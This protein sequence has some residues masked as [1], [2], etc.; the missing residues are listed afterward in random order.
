MILLIFHRPGVCD[1]CVKS[2]FGSGCLSF[3]REPERDCRS[4]GL[5]G[6]GERF[7]FCCLLLL[8]CVFIGTR[9]CPS[10][11]TLQKQHLQ[12]LNTAFCHF[13]LSLCL[14]LKVLS[15]HLL[16]LSFIIGCYC[17]GLFYYFGGWYY[18]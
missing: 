2:H 14:S 5:V 1:V 7:I 18:F 13:S 15:W 6:C 12:Y 10:V 8:F 9:Q 16:F 11:G 17:F 3:N 4:R